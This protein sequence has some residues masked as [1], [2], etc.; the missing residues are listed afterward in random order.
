MASVA[1]ENSATAVTI[2]TNRFGKPGLPP[3]QNRGGLTFNVSHSGEYA[4][5]AFAAGKSLGVDIE[6]IRARET[7]ID[8][9]KAILLPR[10]FAEFERLG[11]AERQR[12]FFR[13]WTR[14][15]AFVKGIGEGLSIP[16]NSVDAE[17]APGWSIHDLDVDPRYAAAVAVQA[18][19]VDLCLWNW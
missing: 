17:G 6:E 3:E 12:V 13:S 16:L 15:E 10:E 18:P 19:T 5:L 11:E 14:K 9:A 8:L 4:L 2:T 7:M 1:V